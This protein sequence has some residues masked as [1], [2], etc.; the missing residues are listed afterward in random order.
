VLLTFYRI[1]LCWL[2]VLLA[3][4]ISAAVVSEVD[5]LGD[6]PMVNIVSRFEQPL[7][8]AP[9]SVTILD[10]ALLDA[11]GAQNWAD[12]F[13]L[14]PG[15]QSY[16]VN[17]NR[18]GVSYHGFG[19]AFPNRLEVMVD[20]RS[21]YEPVFSAV[22]W[23]TLG[24]N[25]EDIDHIE[26]VRGP[27]TP[28]QGSNALLG[29]V[30]IV[31]RTPVQDSG[32]AVTYT[33]GSRAT[34]NASLRHNGQLGGLLYR[35]SLGYQH[36][37]GFPGVELAGSRDGGRELYQMAFRGTLTPSLHDSVD[38]DFGYV[39]NTEDFGSAD[40]PGEYFNS[41]FDSS[42][43]SLSWVRAQANG[44]ELQLRA[45]HNSLRAESR[46]NISLISSA[47]GLP[48][49]AVPGLLGI[50]DQSVAVSL[51]RLS[52]ERFDLQLEQ[53]FA[54]RGRLQAVWGLGAR[55]ESARGEL[56]FGDRDTIREESFRLFSHNEWML[57]RDWVFNFGLM[58]ER[59]HVGTLASPRLALNYQ[60]IANHSLRLVFGRSERSPAITESNMDN[61][62]E[63]GGLAY[64]AVIRAGEG[65][66]EERVDHAELA[67]MA[68]FP[69]AHVELDI[70]VFREEARD[71]IDTHDEDIV[72][73]IPFFDD[74]VK[75]FSNTG[76]WE[77]T[78]VELQFTYKPL[79]GSLLRLHYSYLDLESHYV[80]RLE[81][82][83]QQGDFNT[84][85]PRHS[86]GLLLAYQLT[87][88]L[89]ASVM[90]YYQSAVDWRDS[91]TIGDFSRID[92]QLSYRF[93]CAGSPVKLQLIAQNLGANYAEY[94]H[95]NVFETRFYFKVEVGLP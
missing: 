61:T 81:P 59:S 27:S 86:G 91:N 85:R 47:L 52:S 84:S 69:D 10:R 80:T 82:V 54:R 92:G 21:V 43:Q 39:D 58:L 68:R 11:S 40:Y 23:A 20:G 63:F 31:T 14:V 94:S 2:S 35:L 75:V 22:N 12:I 89:N 93:L 62:L 16:A 38:I 7:N 45:Y 4:D 42:Y 34:S 74:S 53:R 66:A 26:I 19:K 71:G 67:Y 48:P 51:G 60:F 78:G 24:V 57:G 9:A 37:N 88:A 73:P 49:A 1:K 32:T 50:P 55:T 56:L 72:L 3:A 6:I 65:L 25:F 64:N 15:F 29:A 77:T 44:D 46:P 70:S 5:V 28:S 18:Y 33:S 90:T 76:E 41:D 79:P 87:P 30:N 83:K 13:R 17:S 95:N 8:R 36:N